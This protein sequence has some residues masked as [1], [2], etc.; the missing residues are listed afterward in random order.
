MTS[1]PTDVHGAVAPSVTNKVARCKVCGTQWQ[2]QSE[3]TP[4]TDAQGCPFCDAP[5]EAIIIMS[6]APDYGSA[7]KYGL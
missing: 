4:P 7:T 5:A 2:I 1:Y 6:E 3:A